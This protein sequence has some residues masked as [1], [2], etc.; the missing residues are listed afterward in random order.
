MTDTI[1]LDT[2]EKVRMFGLLQ[3][4]H[5]LH[6]EIKTGMPFSNRGASTLQVLRAHGIYAGRSRWAGLWAL[7]RTIAEE[8]GPSDSG[9]LK[10][11]RLLA[12]RGKPYA[13]PRS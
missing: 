10:L 8:G 12:E 4:R 1:V 2:P 9:C 3:I 6:L 13:V 7:N 11:Q 5:K